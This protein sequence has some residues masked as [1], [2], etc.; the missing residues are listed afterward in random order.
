MWEVISRHRINRRAS[1]WV[2]KNNRVR[3]HK[4]THNVCRMLQKI[5]YA[6]EPNHE[7]LLFLPFIATLE[8]SNKGPF[9]QAITAYWIGYSGHG[10]ILVTCIVNTDVFKTL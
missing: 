8:S 7:L 2:Y 10:K 5:K 6:N 4:Y 9:L 1:G 3:A